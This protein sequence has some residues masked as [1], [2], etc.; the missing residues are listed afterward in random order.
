MNKNIDFIDPYLPSSRGDDSVRYRLDWNEGFADIRGLVRHS[1]AE[2]GQSAGSF[3]EYVE[4]S[5][6]DL[7]GAATKFYLQDV[8]EVV[9]LPFAGSD[10]AIAAVAATFLCQDDTVVMP[11]PSYDNARLEFQVRTA[12][13]ERYRADLTRPLGLDHFITWC[14]GL[15]PSMIYLVNPCNPVG[16]LLNPP[17][18]KAIATTFPDSIVLIDEAYIEFSGSPSAI[19]LIHEHPNIMVTRTLSKAFSLASLRV[20]FLFGS[21]KTMNSVN[22]IRNTKAISLL[23]SVV[24]TRALSDPRYMTEFVERIV[25]QREGVQAV[26]KDK[27]VP[28]GESFGNFVV[29][30]DVEGSIGMRL[31]DAGVLYRDR[32]KDFGEPGWIRLTLCPDVALADIIG[33]Q[34]R[35]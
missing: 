34:T 15:A 3:S 24:A 28:F 6:T 22:K 13:I 5:Y 33:G 23:S 27:G 11:V 21:R 16:Y 7:T 20:G 32:A 26:L 14:Q 17:A 29:F 12:R 1:L 19:G 35:V 8:E 9:C 25:R 31:R 2:L 18:I 4:P 30:R 10:S